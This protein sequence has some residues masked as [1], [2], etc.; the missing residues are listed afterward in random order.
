MDPLGLDPLRKKPLVYM[1]KNTVAASG[2]VM[3]ALLNQQSLR[4]KCVKG[5]LTFVLT[6]KAAET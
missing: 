2:D 5:E 6:K 3:P 1:Y 4:I